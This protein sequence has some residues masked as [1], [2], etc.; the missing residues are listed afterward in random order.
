MSSGKKVVG[1]GGELLMHQLVAQDVEFAFTN[2]GS[3]EAGFF[4]AFLS[5][6]GVQPILL[7][8]E[9][10]VLSAADGYARTSRKPAF[11]N[12]HLA[13]GTRQGSGQLYNAYFD[14]TPMVVTAAMRDAGSFGDHNTLG[15][16]GGYS[17][18]N[19]VQDVTKNRWEVR[20]PR[21][22]P[23]ATRRAFK[24]AMSM[25]TGPVYLAY[26]GQALDAKDV[27]GTIQPAEAL[28]MAQMPNEATLE[29]IHDALLN[30]EKPLL[31][32]GPDVT[33]A[34]AQQEVLDL[35]DNYAL[36]VAIGF[37]DY[38]SFPRAHPNFVGLVDALRDDQYDVVCCIGYRPNT[39]ANPSDDRFPN[40][41][42]IGIGHD[43]SMLGNTFALD[44][45]IWANVKNVLTALN[46]KWNPADANLY[47]LSKRQGELTTQSEA[48]L[49]LQHKNALSHANDNPIHPDYLGQR[50]VENLAPNTMVVSEN[51]RASDHLFPFGYGKDDWRYVRTYG[52]SLGHGV[53]CSIGSQIATPDRPLVLSIGDGS[54]MYS[55]SGFW[56]MARYGLPIIT[57]VW[58]NMQYQ[59]VRVNF[60]RW[61]G[62]MKE[63]NKYPET[64]LGD[65]A[66]DFVMLAKAQGIEGQHVYEPGELDAAL[67]RAREVQSAGEPYLLDVHIT[68]LGE[69]ADQ[70]W[71]KA[72]RFN[73]WGRSKVPE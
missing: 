72:F 69:G 37:F 30:A 62:N 51:F 64:Y 53:G 56:T 67:K 59:T 17:Q 3:A 71:Y 44:L 46:H 32:V 48:R 7:L 23:M 20:D 60:A 41:I 54:V 18:I 63:Q 57:V 1:T 13:A 14:G 68:N 8:N 2:T 27:E 36:P 16:P 43:P 45:H 70:N 22:I 52:G 11:V 25:P 49:A 5:V 26:A 12:V 66:I 31:V 73:Q 9:S 6:P 42:K 33:H 24:D 65:P 35:A 61:G 21:G 4:D 50:M 19:A 34:S 10:L 28:D 39:R 55:S 58:N 29:K 15:M 47:H 38:G 40:A